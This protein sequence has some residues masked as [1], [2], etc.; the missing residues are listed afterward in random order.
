MY[1]GAHA[2][3]PAAVVCAK[4]LPELHHAVVQELD[5][6]PRWSPGLEERVCLDE[7]D[8]FSVWET[9]EESEVGVVPAG[10]AEACKRLAVVGTQI[11]PPLFGHVPIRTVGV[12]PEV[13]R[14]FGHIQ[15]S[16]GQ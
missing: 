4:I 16:C 15:S 13:C 11:P 14:W 2:H 3:D 6:L 7:G 9:T 12:V 5:I 10:I 1:V 8:L